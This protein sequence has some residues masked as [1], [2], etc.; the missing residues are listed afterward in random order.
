MKKHLPS[1]PGCAIGFASAG[2]GVG[3]LVGT[4]LHGRFYPPLVADMGAHP[5]GA[6][7]SK[8]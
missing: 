5:A 3:S 7:N 4:F 2:C 1:I 8:S 6:R